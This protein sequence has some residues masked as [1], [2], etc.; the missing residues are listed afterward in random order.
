MT[1]ILIS[2]LKRKRP[3]SVIITGYKNK[4]GACEK[5]SL[6]PTDPSDPVI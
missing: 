1:F 4:E 5:V 3:V 2:R 6:L